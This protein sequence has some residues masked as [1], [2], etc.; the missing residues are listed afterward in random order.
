MQ[1]LPMGY[2]RL[3]LMDFDRK[4]EYSNVVSVRRDADEFSVANIYPVPSDRM[5]NLQVSLS[6]AAT[7]KVTVTDMIG[8]VMQVSE[9]DAIKG[10]NTLDVDMENFAAGTYFVKMGGGLKELTERIVKQ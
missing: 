2:Y 8:R 6:E 3:K 10:V 7:L 9:Y 4:F 5:V 1:P